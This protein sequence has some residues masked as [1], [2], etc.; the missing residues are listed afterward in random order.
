MGNNLAAKNT[1][2]KQVKMEFPGGG[3]CILAPPT[4]L[5]GIRRSHLCY[6][7]KWREHI[8]YYHTLGA[9][10]PD[11]AE[12]S[13]IDLNWKKWY[14]ALSAEGLA[15]NDLD[16]PWDT[17]LYLQSLF[18]R[19][20]KLKGKH[21]EDYEKATSQT[22]RKIADLCGLGRTTWLSKQIHLFS[23]THWFRLLI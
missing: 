9:A 4:V 6:P 7:H 14:Q 16:F 20:T 23:L 5:L 22:K 18:P 11:A 19:Y 21:K 10:F 12:A 15:I 2:E 8:A 17:S 3:N 13:I 1:K